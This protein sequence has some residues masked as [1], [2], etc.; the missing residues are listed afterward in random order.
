MSISI[1][2]I[3]P[4]PE[5]WF[6]EVGARFTALPLLER[7]LC[8]HPV[9]CTFWP[10]PL[11]MAEFQLDCKDFQSWSPSC[12]NLAEVP[13]AHGIGGPRSGELASSGSNA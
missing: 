5:M 9:L 8:W 1:Q 6:S 4:S 10:T 11:T 13:W 7:C 3:N 12:S 2:K